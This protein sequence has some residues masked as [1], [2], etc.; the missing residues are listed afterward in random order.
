MVEKKGNRTQLS[1]V[2]SDLMQW[3]VNKILKNEHSGVEQVNFAHILN[4]AG[5]I[6]SDPCILLI[7]GL[8]I[9]VLPV[10]Y[11]AVKK[12]KFLKNFR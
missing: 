8:L 3:E 6:Y 4:F 5:N 2:L 10:M 11:V 12:N 9:L 1:P 7:F